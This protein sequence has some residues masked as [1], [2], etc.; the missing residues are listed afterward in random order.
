MDT[1]IKVGALI[2]NNNKLLLIKEWSES[3]RVHLW[4]II[5]GSYGDIPNETIVEAAIREC[6][7][8]AG[9][10]VK[11]ISLLNCIILHKKN[12][13][14]IQYNFLAKIISGRP[15]VAKKEEQLSRGENIQ[16]T[17]WFS[18]KELKKL[19]PDAFINKKAFFA[20]Q[21]WL[22]KNDYNL[23]VLR[24]LSSD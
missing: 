5:K 3:D 16:E 22:A 18:R 9:V 15:S 21:D 7:E 17:K 20:V 4:N 6:K 2:V 13:I 23:K 10:K 8:E 11:L 24:Q 1:Q 19:K 12:K 14:R